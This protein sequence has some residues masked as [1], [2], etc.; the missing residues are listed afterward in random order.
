MDHSRRPEKAGREHRVPLSEDALAIL[1]D[2]T[3]VKSGLHVF[4]G[5]RANQPLS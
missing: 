3:E 5:S 4:P 2:M 1:R